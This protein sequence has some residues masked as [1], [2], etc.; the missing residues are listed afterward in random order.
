M[1]LI[2]NIKSSW[3]CGKMVNSL[4]ANDDRWC[5]TNRNYAKSYICTDKTLPRRG[6]VLK[7]KSFQSEKKQECP[8]ALQPHHLPY[9]LKVFESPWTFKHCFKESKHRL[10]VTRCRVAFFLAVTLHHL[11]LHACSHLKL[12]MFGVLLSRS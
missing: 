2:S 6:N 1:T 9:K 8:R 5:P 7:I 12:P 10:P 4:N 3:S 11:L